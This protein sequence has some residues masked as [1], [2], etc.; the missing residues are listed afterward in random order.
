[1]LVSFSVVPIGVGTEMSELIAEI[2]GLLEQSGLAYRLGPMETTVEGPP[3]E[4][5]AVVMG[6]HHHLK[7]Q[8]PRVVTHIAIDDR[9]GYTDQLAAKVDSVQALRADSDAAPEAGEEPTP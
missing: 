1:M 7:Q 8:A 6:C 5:M 4:V 9:S 3:E 2:V